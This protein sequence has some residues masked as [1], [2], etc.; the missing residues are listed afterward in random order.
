MFWGTMSSGPR[1]HMLKHTEQ[2]SELISNYLVRHK[3]LE[4]P[5]WAQVKL[6]RE[7]KELSEMKDR[8]ILIFGISKTESLLDLK[9][10]YLTV[11]CLKDEK[12][13]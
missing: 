11:L 1:P 7:T 13:Y 12:A 8:W 9:I 10:I 5:G 3:S 4:F 2:Y 6:P